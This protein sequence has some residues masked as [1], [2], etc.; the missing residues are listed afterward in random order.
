MSKPNTQHV[1]RTSEGGWAIKRSGATKASGI[2]KTKN[3]AV[4]KARAISRNQRSDLY[5]HGRDGTIRSKDSYGKDV[6]QPKA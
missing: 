4:S 2:Y 6:H 5:I 3:E 1:V